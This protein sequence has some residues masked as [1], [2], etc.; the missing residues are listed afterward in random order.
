MER[1]ETGGAAFP[2]SG[3]GQWAPECGMSLRDYFAAK[4]MQAMISTA[5]GPCFFGLDGVETHT[6]GAAYAVADAMLA[7]R[8]A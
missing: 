3:F 5:D 2:Q 8:S 7:A 6:A 1:E 4:A